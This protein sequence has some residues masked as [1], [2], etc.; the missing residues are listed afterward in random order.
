MASKYKNVATAVDNIIFASKKE[1]ARY[2]ELKMLLLSGYIK[3][4]EWQIPYALKVNGILVCS[5]VADFV[6]EDGA[7]TVVEDVK[8]SDPKF[9]KT[10]A[11]RMFRVKQNLMLACY[12]IQI[13]EV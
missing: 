12:N 7:A 11:Y 8:P 6:F 5:Y 1:A 9:R 13:R 4:L 10:Q 2:A 3:D